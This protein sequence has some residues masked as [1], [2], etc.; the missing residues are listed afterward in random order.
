[1][2]EEHCDHQFAKAWVVKE[3]GDTYDYLNDEWAGNC[4]YD[5]IRGIIRATCETCGADVTD[6]I[7]R[8]LELQRL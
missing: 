3:V 4:E 1:M 5:A 8:I 6:E 7:A 2:R